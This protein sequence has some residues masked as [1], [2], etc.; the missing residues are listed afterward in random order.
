[1]YIY[2]KQSNFAISRDWYNTVNQTY[3]NKKS[4][5]CMPRTYIVTKV[6]Y[7]LIK[8]EKSGKKN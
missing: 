7:F 4:S 1:M 3:F 6:D 8:L 5:I 2:V